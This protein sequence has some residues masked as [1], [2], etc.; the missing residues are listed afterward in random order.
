MIV[1]LAQ[2]AED[3]II[4][5]IRNAIEGEARGAT[6][7]VGGSI[8]VN[9]GGDFDE[10][11]DD[12]TR[13]NLLRP[14]NP[15]QIRFD[16]AG[17]GVTLTLPIARPRPSTSPPSQDDQSASKASDSIPLEPR[18]LLSAATAASLERPNQSGPDQAAGKLG[19][20]DFLTSFSTY[21]AGNIDVVQQILLPYR[22]L[23]EGDRGAR[24]RQIRR[25]TAR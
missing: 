23:K 16:E 24:A 7:E 21:P 5:D 3:A 22:L 4:G 20:P 12:G 11:M 17:Q 19:K 10:D 18:Q 13:E 2:L 15:S 8:P 6:Y 14:P 9:I 1:P 25:C